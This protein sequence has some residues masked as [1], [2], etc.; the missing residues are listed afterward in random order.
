MS[1]K[2]ILMIFIVKETVEIGCFPCMYVIILR[3]MYISMMPHNKS[4]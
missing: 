1:L 4:H 2:E 3:K